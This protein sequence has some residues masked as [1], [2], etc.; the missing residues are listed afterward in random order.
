[1][2]AYWYEPIDSQ[3]MRTF[4]ESDWDVCLVWP[5]WLFLTRTPRGLASGILAHRW[6]VAW[7]CDAI[8]Y[9][10]T[11]LCSREI[12][13]PWTGRSHGCRCFFACLFAS[14][15]NFYKGQGFVFYFTD[16]FLSVNQGPK[17]G[18][19]S[20]GAS[21]FLSSSLETEAS[22]YFRVVTRYMGSGIKGL[23]RGGIW[24]HNQWDR[25][26]QCFSSNQGSSCP[27]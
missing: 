17:G 22:L 20:P 18:I 27:K 16:T 10:V 19:W 15:R 3:W 12:T 5:A 8:F 9:N 4:T 25:N 2:V 11:W 7:S 6:Q 23:N 13:V 21:K 1:M 24:D 26:Q 14:F